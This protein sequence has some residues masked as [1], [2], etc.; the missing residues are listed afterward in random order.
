MKD[1]MANK[2]YSVKE[3]VAYYIY[4]CNSMY[5]NKEEITVRDVIEKIVITMKNVKKENVLEKID[6][7]VLEQ[8]PFLWEFSVSEAVAYAFAIFYVLIKRG[9]KLTDE[10][11]ITGMLSEIYN[12]KPKKTLKEA[13]FIARQVF[14]E[15]LDELE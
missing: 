3:T 15:L 8:I 11:I 2:K 1:Y 14:P 12:F 10:K 9:E 13:E 4:A 5:K 6:K 7:S